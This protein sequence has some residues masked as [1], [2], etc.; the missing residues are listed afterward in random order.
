MESG[1]RL[2][3]SL[4]QAVHEARPTGLF[5]HEAAVKDC[6]IHVSLSGAQRSP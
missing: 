6:A 3:A 5:A 1:R 4:S 2:V